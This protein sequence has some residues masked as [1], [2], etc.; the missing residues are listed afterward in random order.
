[1]CNFA[2]N[3]LEENQNCAPFNWNFVSSVCIDEGSMYTDL[4]K[5]FVETLIS[6]HISSQISIYRSKYILMR[7][8]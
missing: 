7:F 8:R 4:P 3:A 6:N 1:M 2:T 5:V